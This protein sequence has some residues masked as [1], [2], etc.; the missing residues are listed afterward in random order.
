MAYSA[1]KSNCTFKIRDGLM[2]L[3]VIHSSLGLQFMADARG[4]N[5]PGNQLDENYYNNLCNKS[6]GT[7]AFQQTTADIVGQ[8]VN[9]DPT[10]PPSLLRMAF[11]DCFVRVS[12]HYTVF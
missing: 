12:H 7:E 3:L 1:F 9:A 4:G 11:H 6:F 10:L 2:V 5:I 8:F